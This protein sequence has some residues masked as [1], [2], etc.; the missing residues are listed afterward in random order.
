MLRFGIEDAFIRAVIHQKQMEESRGEK[1]MTTL[2]NIM[3]SV[4]AVALLGASGLSAQTK[5]AAA[6]PFEF[7]VQNTTLPAGNYTLA[8]TAPEVIT[9]R[10]AE[11]GKAIMLL[12]PSAERGYRTVQSKNIVVF[13]KVADRYFL[14]D[15]K[16][17]A[18]CGHVIPSRL[19][20]ELTSEGGQPTA[21]VILPALSVR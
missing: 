11:T 4:G 20:R 2:K 3:L 16:T 9:I 1:R 17:D 7:S 8:A 13:H 6:I 15:V 5:A 18:V 12:A 14:A 19:E 10:N 21:A